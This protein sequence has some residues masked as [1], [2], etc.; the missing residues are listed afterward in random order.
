MTICADAVD[1]LIDLNGHTSGGRLALFAYRPAPV[2]VSYLGYPATTGADFIDY[3]LVDRFVAPAD[4]QPFYTERL[5]SCRLLSVQR[6]SAADFRGDA[7][8]RGVRAA[9]WRFR[10]LLFQQPSKNHARPVRHLDATA[11]GCARECALV[12]RRQP[13]GQGRTGAR[14]GKSGRRRRTTCIRAEVAAAGPLGPASAHP[15]LDTLPYNAH[16]T[17]SDALWAGLP[18]VTCPGQRSRAGLRE[19]CC[20]RSECQIWRPLRFRTTRRL[21]CG[22]PVTAICARRCAL[23]WRGTVGR[24]R[25]LIGALGEKRRGRLSAN[26]GNSA[27]WPGAKGIFGPA[28]GRAVGVD[29][30]A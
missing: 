6:R 5:A 21:R 20:M 28:S 17:A 30:P 26:V 2:Q 22:S 29:G 7:V 12:V 9:G 23:D 14:S 16:T 24:V 11:A 19:A 10:L 1:I 18:V 25:C 13:L 8:T 15:F 3:I 4:Q 27:S